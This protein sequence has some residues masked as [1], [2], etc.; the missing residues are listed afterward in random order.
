MSTLPNI[1]I[2]AEDMITWT[3]I[4]VYIILKSLDG[5]EDNTN[6]KAVWFFIHVHIQGYVTIGL[7]SNVGDPFVVAIS[8]SQNIISHIQ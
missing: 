4:S 1:L 6:I 8:W 7:V 2:D 5:N 3:Y